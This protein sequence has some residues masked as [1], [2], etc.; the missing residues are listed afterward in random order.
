MDPAAAAAALVH[1]AGLCWVDRGD[2]MDDIT[3]IVVFFDKDVSAKDLEAGI[4]LGMICGVPQDS[5]ETRNEVQPLSNS[6]R[7]W[8]LFA[9]AASG[10]LGGLCGIRGPPIILYMLHTP[11]GVNFTKKSQRATGAAITATNVAMRVFY[12]LLNTLAFGK[13]SNFNREDWVLYLVVLVVSCLGVFLG[14][15]LFEYTKD[16][17][18]TIRGILTIF[19]LLCGASLL[20]SSY[21]GI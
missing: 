12:Y 20:I 5:V 16:S 4:E 7:F 9:G 1:E 13:S 17:K 2:Y 10:F 18:A 3:A 8:T 15:K 19:L 6:A 11:A 21:A 14:S